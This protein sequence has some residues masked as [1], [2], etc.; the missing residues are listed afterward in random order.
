MH[1]A[2][3]YGGSTYLAIEANSNV[4]PSSD[5]TKWAVLAQ[6]GTDGDGAGDMTKLDYDTDEDGKVNAAAQ[7]DVADGVSFIDLTTPP[8]DGQALVYDATSEKFKPGSVAA[9]GVPAGGTTGQVLQKKS[10]SDYDTEWGT[11]TGSGGSDDSTHSNVRVIRDV[12]RYHAS[13]GSGIMK[14][15]M[16]G[17]IGGDTFIA[18]EI[19]GFNHSS[20]VSWRA[21]FAGMVDSGSWSYFSCVLYPNCPFTQMRAGYDG[22]NICILLGATSTSWSYPVVTVPWVQLAYSG[23]ATVPA[24]WNVS[25]ITTETGL[26]IGTT[27]S[28]KTITAT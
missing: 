15:A 22:T 14:L 2:A 4:T 6:K 8:S 20:K 26:S 17:T 16:P 12:A 10:G 24:Q 7:A 13:G 23:M 9:S 5:P 19:L 21:D 28:T 3:T 27:T 18:G 11:V 1:D 25:I